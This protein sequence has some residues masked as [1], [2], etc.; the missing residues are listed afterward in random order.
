MS[1]HIELPEIVTSREKL[2]HICAFDVRHLWTSIAEQI[3]SIYAG[4]EARAAWGHG[5]M[6][7]MYD[8]QLWLDSD[9][10]EQT[11]DQLQWAASQTR[12]G[13]HHAHTHLIHYKYIPLLQTKIQTERQPNRQ[14]WIEFITNRQIDKKFTDQWIISKERQ[15]HKNMDRQTQKY[16][17]TQAGLTYA[18]CV[19]AILLINWIWQIVNRL[20]PES[21]LCCQSLS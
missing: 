13:R 15:T 3:T 14:L 8:V 4:F 9:R 1:W 5:W 10:W 12:G 11:P 6:E 21:L 16:G 18:R 20:I 17:Q 19:D 2:V 7:G